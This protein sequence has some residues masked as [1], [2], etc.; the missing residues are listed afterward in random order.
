M[1][2]QNKMLLMALG[3]GCLFTLTGKAQAPRLPIYQVGRTLG[4]IKID[5]KLDDTAWKKAPL[6]GDFVNNGRFPKYVQD[7]GEGALR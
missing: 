1:S 6:V 3:L 5:G 4:P 7:R 2:R